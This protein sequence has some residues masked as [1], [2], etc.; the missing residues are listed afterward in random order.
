MKSTTTLQILDRL[1]FVVT[2]ILLGLASAFGQNLVKNPGFEDHTACP[3]EYGSFQEDV[4][5]W[6]KPTNGSTDYF[7]LCGDKLSTGKNFIG[8]QKTYEGNAYAGF[9]AYGPNGYRE[10]IGGELTEKLEK[11][12]KYKFSF[13]VSLAEKSQFAISELSIL[14]S[15]EPIELDTKT[16][17]SFNMLQRRRLKNYVS[18]TNHAY[19]SNKQDWMEVSGEYIANGTE[20]YIVLGNFKSNAETK[21]AKVAKNLKKAAYYYID[22]I[23][24]A[25]TGM[26]LE[27]D[28]T[29]V[30]ENLFFEVNGHEIIGNGKKELQKL[31]RHLKENP[32]LNIA[33]YGHTDN[34][35]PKV[36]NKELSQKRAKE[37]GLFLLENGLSSSRIAW[38]GFGDLVPL[39]A[40]ETEEGRKKNRRVEFVVSEKGQEFYA[41]NLFEDE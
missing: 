3:D 21:K 36:L 38:K 32:E 17:I 12:K 11:G 20:Q 33:I 23:S 18:V 1:L 19:F 9:Y 6:Y 29:Y 41:S 14:F 15:S 27:L 37:V 31:I 22:M 13:R 25:P 2:L 8:N 39:A 34:V 40:N 5:S 16:N 28:E 24:V 7:N 10:Y 35:G 30:L 4:S 26:N